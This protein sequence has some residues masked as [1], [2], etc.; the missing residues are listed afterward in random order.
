MEES[1]CLRVPYHIRRTVA[2]DAKRELPMRVRRVLTGQTETGESVFVSDDF[3]DAV[4]RPS[5]GG[6]YLLWGSDGPLHLPT[7]G[8]TD[9]IPSRVP[10]AG[11]VRVLV[12]DYDPDDSPLQAPS[13]ED[14]AEFER[15]LPSFDRV[16]ERDPRTGMHFTNTVDIAF[17]L[18]GEITLVQDGGA[19]V[20]LRKG[21]V[22][23]QNGARHVWKARKGVRCVVGVVLMGTNRDD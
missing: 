4:H 12:I 14:V 6:T 21:D 7:N 1:L 18:E 17:V 13:P 15:T 22:L 20:L 2:D 10:D 3:V 5:G 23:I 19:Q 9:F 16:R 8:L 11:G